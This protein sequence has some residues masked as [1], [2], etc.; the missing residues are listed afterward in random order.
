MHSGLGTERSGQR[1]PSS[2]EK[3]GV[4]VD[5][6]E[7]PAESEIEFSRQ[8]SERVNSPKTEFHGTFA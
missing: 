3:G 4:P 2:R 7:S 8:V 6:G 1:L 5:S